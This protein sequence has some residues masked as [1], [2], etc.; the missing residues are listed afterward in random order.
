MNRLSFQLS[1]VVGD[2]FH[3]YSFLLPCAV[4]SWAYRIR[5]PDL[6]ELLISK[7]SKK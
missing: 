2:L 5:N 4:S 1:E 7:K 3:D 6:N